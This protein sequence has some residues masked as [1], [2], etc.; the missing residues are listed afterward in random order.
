MNDIQSGN[1]Q[2]AVVQPI[3]ANVNSAKGKP[4]PRIF[5]LYKYL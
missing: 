2:Q 1:R 3:P 4:L 5:Q